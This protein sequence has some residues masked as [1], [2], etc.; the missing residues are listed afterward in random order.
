MI[1]LESPRDDSFQ[2]QLVSY[3]IIKSVFSKTSCLNGV[4]KA[5]D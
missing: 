5:F 2:E 4:L 1:G 3:E